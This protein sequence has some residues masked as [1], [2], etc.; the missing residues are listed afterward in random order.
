MS[1]SNE[2]KI[3]I[4]EIHKMPENCKA[5]MLYGILSAAR[6]YSENEIEFLSETKEVSEYTSK[7]IGRLYHINVPV[8]S[9]NEA[10]QQKKELFQIKITDPKLCKLICNSF[11]CGKYAEAVSLI[12]LDEKITWS[13]IKGIFLGCGSVSGP[14]AKYHLEFSFKRRGDA[15]FAEN[16]LSSLSLSPKRTTRREAY[17][18]Y[19]KDSTSIEDILAGIGAVKKVLQLMDTKV[20]KDLRNRLNRRNNCETANLQRTISACTQQVNAIQYIISKRGIE[21]LSDDLQRI[22]CFRLENPE[23]SLSEMAKELSGEF[24]K[25]AIDRRLK[26]LVLTANELKEQK[27]R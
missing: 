21:Y 14:D 5:V 27:G 2:V 22:A 25:S 13:F 6:T 26:K 10:L 19:F 1:F 7:L 4:C 17:L 8:S 12:S 24:S 11:N 15:V 18:I 20:I 9:M 23:M 16:M 3:E